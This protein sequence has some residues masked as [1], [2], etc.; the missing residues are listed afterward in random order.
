MSNNSRGTWFILL[1]IAIALVMELFPLPDSWQVWRP[2]LL[3][4]VLSYWVIELPER[5]GML[6]ALIC[7]LL[8]DALLNTSMGLHGFA[9]AVTSFIIVLLHKRIRLFPLWKQA[10]TMAFISGI[11]IALTFWLGR[12]TGKSISSIAWQAT[13]TNAV[14]W[15]W[16]Y[17][18][19]KQLASYFKVRA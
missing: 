11:F 1:T 10:L 13:I 15:P 18:T 16:L 2:T 3:M 12:L 8:L 4:L 17:I 9:L 5:I 6:W 19:L 14:L 7:G